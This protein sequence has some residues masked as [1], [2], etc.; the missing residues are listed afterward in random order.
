MECQVVNLEAGMPTVDMARIHLNM[1][2]RSAKA[3]R[4][5]ALKLIHGYGSS[6]KGGAIRADVLAQLAQKKRMGQIQEFVRGE[7]FSP[8]D[9]GARVIVAAC[10]SLTRDA[11]YSRANHGIT[12]VLL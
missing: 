8:F 2:L 9:S 10:P 5:K 4:T 11:D 3:N 6:G 1:A 12:M 7:D